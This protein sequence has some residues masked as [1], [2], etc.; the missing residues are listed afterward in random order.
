MLI[1]GFISYFFASDLIRFFRNDPDV[2]SIGS[3]MMRIQ[4]LS[5]IF[6]PFAVYSDMMFQSIGKKFTAMFLASLRRGLVLIPA[7]II[8]SHFFNLTGLEYSQGISD[9]ITSL[10]CY[11]FS[12]HFFRTMPNDGE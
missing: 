11:P 8:L 4:C 12:L 5:I 10:I 2:I 9:I 7:V 3:V 6:S 1:F